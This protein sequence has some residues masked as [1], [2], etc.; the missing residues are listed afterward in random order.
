MA[1]FQ[2]SNIT[3]SSFAGLGGGVVAAADPI[4]VTWQI[5]GN[6]PM[7]G[8]RIQVL[9]GT[10]AATSVHDTGYLAT[11]G[12]QYATDAHGN[13]AFFTYTPETGSTWASWGLTDGES[14]ALKITQYW[15]SGQE[16]AVEQYSPAQF[17]T[18][19]APTL[20]VDA[21]V[22]PVGSISQTFTASYSQAQ[23]DPIN[24]VRWQFAQVVNGARVIL[25]DTGEVN[26][27][28]LSYT[29]DGLQ[30]GQTYAVNCVVQT[31]S[32]V[33]TP[34]IWDDNEF[35][36]SYAGAEVS[37]EIEVDC[38]DP[39]CNLV[40]WE[41]LDDS[42]SIPGTAQGSTL[43]T[44][45]GLSMGSV[46]EVEWN[47]PAQGQLS[48][49]YSF[50]WSGVVNLTGL[51]ERDIATDDI[52]TDPVTVFRYSP[53]GNYQFFRADP[54]AHPLN[55]NVVF[56][57]TLYPFG[58]L[59]EYSTL[60]DAAF[61]P[62]SDCLAL[63][64][65]TSTQ[66]A[67]L[68]LY[69]IQHQSAS[70]ISIS[71]VDVRNV[72]SGQAFGVAF[73]PD[74]KLLV[75]TARNQM[76]L[77]Q[78]DDSV[79][80]GDNNY[81]TNE[82]WRADVGPFQGRLRF[83]P[84]GQ[85]LL[86]LRSASG[87]STSALLLFVDQTQPISD[88]STV[89]IPMEDSS[90][91]VQ[92][93]FFNA[94]GNI[95]LVGMSGTVEVFSAS[96]SDV[97]LLSVNTALPSL[98][99]PVTVS[100]SAMTATGD[101][102]LVSGTF[103]SVEGTY[104]F[105]KSGNGFAQPVRALTGYVTFTEF[106]PSGM[107]YTFGDYG[108]LTRCRVSA[109]GSLQ[110]VQGFGDSSNTANALRLVSTGLKLTLSVS[111]RASSGGTAVDFWDASVPLT[112]IATAFLVGQEAT[113][114]AVVGMTGP[115]GSGVSLVVFFSDGTSATALLQGSSG[116]SAS[117]LPTLA[118]VSL[119][120]PQTCRWLTFT[121]QST[122]QYS[123]D[124]QPPGWQQGVTLLLTHF[125]WNTLD[126]GDVSPVTLRADLYRENLR[127]GT[128]KKLV[129]APADVSMLRDFGWLTGKAYRYLLYSVEDGVYS[130]PIASDSVCR[131]SRSYFLIEAEPD[132]QNPDVYH[133]A[134]YWRFS[135]NL[136]SGAVSNNN[137]PNFGTNFTRYR[138]PQPAA[139]MGRSGTLSSLLSNVSRYTGRYS[140][141]AEE[142]QE[143]FEASASTNPFFLKDMKGNL[144]MVR[145]SAPITQTIRESSSAQY[146]TVSLPWEEIGD[147]DGV[148]LIQ[149]PG[150][151]GWG[152][153]DSSPLLLVRL[154]VDL[155][156]GLLMEQAP[157]GYTGVTFTLS[158]NSLEA[159]VDAIVLSA[160]IDPAYVQPEIVMQDGVVY[161]SVPVED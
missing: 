142:M 13:P 31:A 33:V 127:D 138:L 28:V 35:A 89:Y 30:S 4:V 149:L 145:I 137:T 40:S 129:S 153:A 62:S 29:V 42:T 64:Y 130:A 79:P 17:V 111:K 152:L 155:A 16:N 6:S 158:Q 10:A 122:V 15:G 49:P 78:V 38:S 92:D 47:L 123:Y 60:G 12:P 148:S 44:E 107:Q 106:S 53:D 83:S 114:D 76:Y 25:D 133:V 61:S 91:A 54:D 93:A 110:F 126:A 125:D 95:V 116:I 140:D 34:D 157:Q 74:G 124:Y 80:V 139:R 66:Y 156:T 1:L 65:S 8:F 120:G 132:A 2:P 70:N 88:W 84:D 5:N 85:R 46:S 118:R 87:S 48:P 37:G 11:S 96:A 58:T 75:Y 159:P 154:Y 135:A 71:F 68:D 117:A 23:G 150:D 128:L 82:S 144:Y 103:G 14:Y 151:Q 36:V 67:R 69:S 21:F 141:T 105:S 59:S 101:A 43:F 86:T 143:L 99:G 112:G 19:T 3:P 26:T 41:Q 20:T 160:Q 18:R 77:W 113:L 56:A 50:A 102:L 51:L 100:Y 119:T 97:T 134:R 161:A 73:S 90:D 81:L 131:V 39:A 45:D 72:T 136:S 24:W 121:N 32:G 115:S 9:S 57:D 52:F 108:H 98:G 22:R 94:D 147:A 104:G 7:T 63:A 146:V 55:L 109:G 27:N